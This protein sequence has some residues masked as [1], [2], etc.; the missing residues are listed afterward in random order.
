MY[1]KPSLQRFGTF[2]EVTRGGSSSGNFDSS[3][4]NWRVLLYR[5]PQQVL[6]G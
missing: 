4:S 3:H 5:K 2:R 1:E 6:R